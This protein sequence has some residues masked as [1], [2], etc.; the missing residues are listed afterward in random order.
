MS[1]ANHI[2]GQPAITT[3]QICQMLGFTVSAQFIEEELGIPPDEKT[4]TASL[5]LES[6]FHYICYQLGQ[7]V[8]EVRQAHMDG[9][10][11]PK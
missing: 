1:K 8:F 3:T 4:K 7:Y 5:W 11:Q 10:I 9:D 6:K 2:M